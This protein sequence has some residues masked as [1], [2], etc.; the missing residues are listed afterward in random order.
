LKIKDNPDYANNCVFLLADYANNAAFCAKIGDPD[1]AQYCA[2]KLIYNQAVAAKK[3]SLC[4]TIKTAGLNESCVENVINGLPGLKKS[5]CDTLPDR[6]RPYCLNYLDF[7][8]AMAEFNQAKS[9]A[10]CQK[11]TQ[12]SVQAECLLKYPK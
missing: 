12:F 6:E 11:I 3:I 9:A 10:D 8:D 7:M 5:D 1:K 4:L 2:D